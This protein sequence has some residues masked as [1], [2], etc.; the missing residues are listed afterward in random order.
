MVCT[1]NA[2]EYS[3]L[4]CVWIVEVYVCV[5]ASVCVVSNELKGVYGSLYSTVGAEVDGIQV[6]RWKGQLG[7]VWEFI[8]DCCQRKRSNI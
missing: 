7:N 8:W 2:D 5:S 3:I 6:C 4:L 1:V